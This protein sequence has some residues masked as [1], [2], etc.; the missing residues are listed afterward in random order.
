MSLAR[1]ESI[2][3][4]L[5]FA[6]SSSISSA[7]Y[8]TTP[9]SSTTTVPGPGALTGKAVKAL[10]AVTLKG[11]ELL[12]MARHWAAITHAFPHTDDQALRTRRIDDLYDDLLEFS[13]P[14]MYSHDV[15]DRALGLILAQIGA[16]QTQYLVKALSRWYSVELHIL[17]SSILTQVAH[18]WNPSLRG[19]FSSPLST[20]YT[21]SQGWEK[22]EFPILRLILFLSRLIRSSV[23]TCRVVLDVGFLDVLVAL[24]HNFDDGSI[25]NDAEYHLY[26]A[27]N[28]S[29]LDITGYEEN[30]WVVARHPIA[31]LW[32]IPSR[33]IDLFPFK[34]RRE[35]LLLGPDSD[36]ALIERS[37]FFGISIADLCSQ[38][39]L[40]EIPPHELLQILAFHVTYD[41]SVRVFLIRG[42]YQKKVTL[43]SKL[44]LCLLK[45]IKL[46]SISPSNPMEH[47]QFSL[48][49]H[50]IAAVARTSM[51]NK[52]ALMDA[53]AANYLVEAVR[54]V[55]PDAYKSATKKI[56]EEGFSGLLKLSSIPAHP[57]QR[58][59]SAA[60]T[61]LLGGMG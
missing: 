24:C 6:S 43:L 7:N 46:G 25:A 18:L 14:G 34:L 29:L 39:S 26:I 22:Q 42:T 50:F 20:A 56:R 3:S 48:S 15:N 53:G 9:G 10:G 33:Q 38:R 4:A 31:S 21:N 12:V 40:S 11:F 47:Y 27:C 5:S 28:A 23:S 59:L 37:P 35:A 61:A 17:L 49:L 32:P 58:S 45:S 16:G 2:L 55:I 57:L 51:E 19:L 36:V 52:Q 60:I 8:D 30:R 13:R 41:Q 1:T 54:V 44:L